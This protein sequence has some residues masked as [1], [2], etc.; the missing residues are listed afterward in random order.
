[1]AEEIEKL[2]ITIDSNI[3]LL[4]KAVKEG[5]DGLEKELRKV[6]KVGKRTFAEIKKAAREAAT[7][8]KRVTKEAAAVA[9]KAAKEV[10]AAKKKA[11]KAAAAAIRR[12]ATEEKKAIREAAAV[13]KKAAAEAEARANIAV[14][15]AQKAISFFTD[16]G[17]AILN[18]G[19]T[20]VM[21]NAQFETY[22]AQFETLLGSTEAAQER[23]E[24]LA[25]FGVETPFELPGIVEASR[26]L[27]VFG[28]ETLATGDNLRMVGDIA[29]GVN[30][31]FEDVAFWI[32]RMF[33]AMQSGR[34]FGEASARLQE[35]GALSGEARSE[36]EKLTKAG[37]SGAELWAKFNELVGTR[38]AGNMDRL[39]KTFQG[40]TSNL[41]DFRDNL[42][43]IGGE[44]L[45][46]EVRDN[47]QELLDIVSDPE[48]S[49][50]MEN[51]ATALGVAAARLTSVAT[52][53]FMETLTDIETEKLDQLAESILDAA[54]AINELLSPENTKDF[55]S[56]IDLLTI[57][58]DSFT[59]LTNRINRFTGAGEDSVFVLDLARN[60]IETMLNPI[61][62]LIDAF[63]NL[64]KAMEMDF[65]VELVDLSRG[66]ADA[67]E[68]TA[69]AT[70]RARKAETDRL[71]GLADMFAA[72][73]AATEGIEETTE[74]LEEQTEEL[75]A[76]QKALEGYAD[77]LLDLT[78]KNVEAQEELEEGHVQRIKEI[79]T[80]HQEDSLEAL[81]E[82]N[83]AVSDAQEDHNKAIAEAEKQQSKATIEAERDRNDALE[84]LA[85]ELAKA[86]SEVIEQAREDL[87]QLEKDTDRKLEEE[88]KN[89]QRDELRG[90][91]DHLRNMRRIRR[92]FLDDIDDAVKNRDARALVDA[93]KRF[94][95]ERQ[96]AEGARQTTQERDQEDQDLRL[97]QIE[98]EEQRRADEIMSAQEDEL[99]RLTEHEA[100]KQ[101]EIQDSFDRQIADINEALAEQI[102]RADEHFAE[103]T[104]MAQEQFETE[105]AQADERRT[106]Q[107]EK[108]NEQ[109]EKR[110]AE[111]ENATKERL[112]TI[113][114]G[115]ADE[116][117]INEDEARRIL[118]TLSEYFGVDGEIDKLMEDFAKRRRQKIEIQISFSG[119]DI[120]PSPPGG[121]TM[122]D[123]GGVIPSFQTGG[124]MIAR[125]PTLAQ[126]G[127]V[128]E[129][130]QFTP[131]SQLGGGDNTLRIEGEIKLSGSA[132][133]GIRSSERDQIAA[134]LVNAFREAGFTRS[135]GSRGV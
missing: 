41:A 9:K 25:R 17:N 37:A 115:L 88:R 64:N 92:R 10:E 6:E 112:E 75:S 119:G 48:M 86:R 103:Q 26:I 20:V 120:P 29:T 135:G 61:G 117:Q 76:A 33:D 54:N 106:Q 130:V 77:D 39:S 16:I 125:R 1:M 71:Q 42:M 19:K 52:T 118:E 87:S 89:F 59:I 104:A 36:I 134:V 14:F 127:E 82:F 110:R 45:F 58:V 131:L 21:A 81:E 113:A 62:N 69:Q 79:D 121:G 55:T 50:S 90:T 38:F 84:Q 8:E 28:G 80:E 51:L 27:E 5:S 105:T 30:L 24:E 15:V 129:L 23:M 133:P 108:E 53:P 124:S 99:N 13:A 68:T 95:Q 35:M 122:A 57:L 40:V 94:A 4:L 100:Q 3:N 101:T 72:Q 123:V 102:T 31:P 22:T 2:I 43:R 18:L 78:E 73:Q 132:P 98:E 85:E 63:S 32:G 83:D 47:A 107:L 34:P 12:A 44:P 67:T 56:L 109:F 93:R 96:E 74:A 66:L 60:A 70:D 46:E 91:E 97:R 111:L 114:K 126:F 128:P 116:E 11:A 49:K 65:G 7:E